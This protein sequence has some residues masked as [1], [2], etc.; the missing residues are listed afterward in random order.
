MNDSIKGINPSSLVGTRDKYADDIIILIK[1]EKYLQ[2]A[3]NTIEQFSDSPGP[4]LNMNKSEI[5]ATGKYRNCHEICGIRVESNVRCL[6]IN[7]GHDKSVCN[8]KNWTE[9][10]DKFCHSGKID[11]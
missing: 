11:I 2:I 6:G 8:A 9:K 5:I 3:I 10:I 4:T 1:D 7:V